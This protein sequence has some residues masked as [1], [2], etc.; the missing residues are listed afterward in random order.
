MIDPSELKVQ[1]QIRF[2]GRVGVVTLRMASYVEVKWEDFLS[3]VVYYLGSIG[4]Y[5]MLQKCFPVYD[6]DLEEIS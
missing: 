6:H 1:D 3:S 4:D 2:D 5:A